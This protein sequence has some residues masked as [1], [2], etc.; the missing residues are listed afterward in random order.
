M[1]LLRLQSSSEEHAFWP[2]RVQNAEEIESRTNYVVLLNGSNMYTWAG[3]PYRVKSVA[4]TPCYLRSKDTLP[5]PA[6]KLRAARCYFLP[7]YNDYAT[8]LRSSIPIYA[9]AL[10]SGMAPAK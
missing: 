6:V 7:N 3:P 4:Q 1:I 2:C 5:H 9:F 8:D 10:S